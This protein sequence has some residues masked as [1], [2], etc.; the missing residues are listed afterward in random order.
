MPSR[1]DRYS[2]ENSKAQ[3]SRSEKNKD[4]YENIGKNTRYTNFTDIANATTIDLSEQTNIQTRQGYHKVK[5]YRE[6]SPKPKARKEL[7]E[8]DILYQ[9]HENK[10]YDVNRIL[11]QAHQQR[12]SSPE[13]E[14]KRK[15]KDSSYNIL[16][17]LTKEEL[18]Q[19]RKERTK[20]V[21]RP[22][23]EE[24]KEL[25]DTI[26]SKTLAGE[27]DKATSVNLLS[28]LM[29]TSAID[30]V[31]P[32][33]EDTS[34]EDKK[35]DNLSLSKEVLDKEQLEKIKQVKEFESIDE[36]KKL[37]NADND[38][39]TKSMDLSD[40]DF[41]TTLD[42]EDPK[43]SPVLKIMIIIIILIAIGMAIYFIWKKFL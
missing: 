43:M 34:F 10:I 14:E 20:K 21:S 41:E 5:N 24:L 42:F 37:T 16:T 29:A 22:N 39:Y 31:D 25:I 6:I 23:E 4:L 28:D 3:F 13:E 27:I 1:M 19:Y 26:T 30:K 7:D 17:N 40:K 32:A 8:I 35:E 2:S 15:L 12:V 36:E 9:D 33:L 11:E 38:F 18:E